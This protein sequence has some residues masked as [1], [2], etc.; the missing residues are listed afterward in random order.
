MPAAK[1]PSPRDPKIYERPAESVAVVHTVGDP[2]EVGQSAIGALYGAVYTLKFARKKTGGTD[3][4]VGPLRARWSN[5]GPE[6]RAEMRGAWA[7][8]VPPDTTELQQKSPDVEVALEQWEYGPVG[9]ILHIGPYADEPATIERLNAFIAAEG[10]E[11]AGDHEEE[12][13]TRPDAKTVKTLIRYR[14][15]RA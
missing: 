2:N 12:Y 14:L 13:L 7:L 6:H 1:R 8:P 4:K 10:F 15:R 5:L 9:E 11:V 3:F